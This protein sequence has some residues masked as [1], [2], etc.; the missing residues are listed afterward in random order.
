MTIAQPVDHEVPTPTPRPAGWGAWL[1]IRPDGDVAAVPE[2]ARFRGESSALRQWLDAGAYAAAVERLA[3]RLRAADVHYPARMVLFD[4]GEGIVVATVSAT[5]AR[6]SA[7]RHDEAS[8]A[9]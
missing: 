7:W 6:L 2:R 8:A 1:V 5:H 9:A 3:W 4:D